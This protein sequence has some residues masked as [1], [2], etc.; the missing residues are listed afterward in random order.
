MT[1]MLV[2][3]AR[4]GMLKNMVLLIGM[5]WLLVL[6]V[7]AVVHR[8]LPQRVCLFTCVG[9]VDTLIGVLLALVL[10]TVIFQRRSDTTTVGASMMRFSAFVL[11]GVLLS[12]VLAVEYN[13]FH[14]VD[15]KRAPTAFVTS[16]FLTAMLFAAAYWVL[17]WLL[18]YA[19]FFRGLST[20]LIVVLVGLILWA[21]VGKYYEHRSS[22]SYRVFFSVGV[23][24][25][26]LF[27]FSDMVLLTT[28]CR[29]R[30]S[31]ECDPLVGATTVYIDMVNILQNLFHLS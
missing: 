24:V 26:L 6:I 10:F 4:R 3:E 30:G 1:P 31:R 12:W 15:P 18:P 16:W 20:V 28:A 8:L 19:E 23:L 22:S 14:L 7:T 25:F 13:A 11:L 21:L 5:Q 17:P 29:R 2:Q 9:W 27:L